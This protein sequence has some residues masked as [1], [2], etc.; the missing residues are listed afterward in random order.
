V[1]R[2]VL[3][4]HGRATAGWSEDHDP[5]LDGGGRAQAERVAQLLAARPPRPIVTSPLRRARETAAPLEAAWG[6]TARVEPM[7]GEIP[8]P[9]DALV[10]RGQW[11]TGVLR[12]RWPEL[13][14]DVQ[15]W[16]SAV[17]ETLV[18]APHHCVAFT[19]YVAI[20]VAVGAATDDDR[21]VVFHPDNCSVTELDVVDGRL[22]LVSRGD[23]APTAVR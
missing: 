5:G 14:H 7:V 15:A 13:D 21:V 9:S 18:A 19:H 23:E 8:S 2:L 20:N 11:L 12:S 4:R 17:V 3:V 16:R 1:T 6:V 22:V 10:S